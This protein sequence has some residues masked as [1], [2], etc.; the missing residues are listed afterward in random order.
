MAS[1]TQRIIMLEAFLSSR[2]TQASQ[3]NNKK[4]ITLL[5]YINT[6]GVALPPTLIY[7]GDSGSL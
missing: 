3:D 6:L 2:I 5:A 4:F 7:Q 1:A